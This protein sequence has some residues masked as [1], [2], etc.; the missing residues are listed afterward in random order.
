MKTY[1]IRICWPHDSTEIFIIEGYLYLDPT[2]YRI[3]DK[4]NK[5]HYY[6]LQYTKIDEQ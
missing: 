4:D 6:P 1:K 2:C 3:M 5:Y